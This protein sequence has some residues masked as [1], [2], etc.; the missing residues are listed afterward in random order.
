[1]QLIEIDNPYSLAGKKNFINCEQI[2]KLFDYLGERSAILIY[3]FVK[4]F[5]KRIDHP[6]RILDKLKITLSKEPDYSF[7]EF[8]DL[9]IEKNKDKPNIIKKINYWKPPN[10]QVL[11]KYLS[12]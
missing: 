1:M 4:V 8:L 2:L 3:T 6:D 7:P 9:F 11:F 12:P 5:G 10:V